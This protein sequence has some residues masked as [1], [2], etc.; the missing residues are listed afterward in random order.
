M[1]YRSF[2]ALRMTETLRMTGVMD[3]AGD[4]SASVTFHQVLNFC[5]GHLVEVPEDG[6]F[7]A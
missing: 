7:Q 5:N 6:V 3:L 2:A 1:C 4:P